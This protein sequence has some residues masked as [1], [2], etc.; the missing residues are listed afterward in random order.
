MILPWNCNHFVLLY[1]SSNHGNSSYFQNVCIRIQ[2]NNASYY[3]YNN[4]V[5][6]MT[7][8]LMLTLLDALILHISTHNQGVGRV[9]CHSLYICIYSNLY[10]CISLL[11]K[12]PACP[13]LLG[14]SHRALSW[15]SIIFNLLLMY[16]QTA[17]VPYINVCLSGN[18]RAIH[19]H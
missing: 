7:Q 15:S 12:G 9:Q 10:S 4:T 17:R 16:Q 5:N 3:T 8:C 14:I 19:R 11:C 2:R 13:A 6:I 18:W 1:L